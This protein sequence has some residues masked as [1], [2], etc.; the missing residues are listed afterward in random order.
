TTISPLSLHDALPI[1]RCGR[2]PP[3]QNECAHVGAAIGSSTLIP[4]I[5]R[6]GLL[7]RLHEHGDQHQDDS[8][9]QAA[10]RKQSY[11]GEYVL[12]RIRSEEHTSELQSLAY[13]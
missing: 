12:V 8:K 5:G 4:L 10:E 11:L 13:L 1:W 7:R 6:Q 9:E 3:Q 2:I